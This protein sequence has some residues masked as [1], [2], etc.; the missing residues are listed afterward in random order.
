MKRI[1]PALILITALFLPGIAHA[2]KNTAPGAQIYGIHY[3]GGTVPAAPSDCWI[4]ISVTGDSTT[5]YVPDKIH[6]I[7]KPNLVVNHLQKH[8]D[9]ALDF[10]I[11]SS[12]IKTITLSQQKHHRIGTGIAVS[13]VSLGAGIPVMFTKSTKDYIGLT[14]DNNGQRGAAEFQADKSDYRA[15]LTALS[16]ASGVPV[17]AAID[18]EAGK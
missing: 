11:P 2:H 10:S 12:A 14:W 13:V 15:L 5:F 7:D 9:K 8:P 4:G 3:G 6:H 18:S 17:T 1:S 16:G